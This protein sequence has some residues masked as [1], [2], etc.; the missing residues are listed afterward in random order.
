METETKVKHTPGPWN[1]APTG[2]NMRDKYT[3]PFGV[4]TYEKN[5]TLIAGCFGDVRGGI[6]AAEAN[7]RLIAAAPQL[8]EALKDALDALGTLRD[9]HDEVC[10]YST[11]CGDSVDADRA[12]KAGEA[13]IAAAEGSAEGSQ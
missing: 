11:C 3:Q 1:S 7:A 8:L 10:E 13:A 9:W 5:P 2:S 12:L 6:D 4:A